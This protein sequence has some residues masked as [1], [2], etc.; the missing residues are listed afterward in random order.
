MA[1][2][3]P[4]IASA[5]KQPTFGIRTDK[6]SLGR[7]RNGSSPKSAAAAASQVI[8]DRLARRGHR[9]G[10]GFDTA[11]VL[12]TPVVVVEI[13]NADSADTDLIAGT[14]STGQRRPA[15]VT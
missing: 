8:A 5:A 13:V 2:A 14:A 6:L 1:H 3:L 12:E 4:V 9:M 11:G 10:S 15:Y 7:T